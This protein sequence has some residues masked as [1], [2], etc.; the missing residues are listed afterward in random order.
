MSN[1]NPVTPNI[2]WTDKQE[3]LHVTALLCGKG[4]TGKTSFTATW[5][6]PVVVNCDHGETSIRNYHIPMID[7]YRA[8]KETPEGAPTGWMDIR[9]IVKDFRFKKGPYW[10]ALADYEPKTLIIDSLSA[11]CDILEAEIVYKNP[12]RQSG[13]QIQDYNV[14]GR[15]VV[16]ILSLAREIPMHFLATSGLEF[17]TDKDSGVASPKEQPMTLGNKLGAK[18]VHYFH[19]VYLHLKKQDKESVRFV[20]TPIPTKHFEHP[21]SRW[22]VPMVEIENPSYEK[23]AQYYFPEASS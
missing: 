22:G 3:N 15:R 5:P 10:D 4:K 11:M 1:Q 2:R 18:V 9:E 8:E 12:D 6:N 21:G 17:V 20:L 19:D 23:L 13:L 14:I 16:S 7:I